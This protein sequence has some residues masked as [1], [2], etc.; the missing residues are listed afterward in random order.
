[1]KMNINS[2]N[3]GI[4]QN[5]HDDYLYDYT[6]N[7]MKYIVKSN[8]K[9]RVKGR[10]HAHDNAIP[11]TVITEFRLKSVILNIVYYTVFGECVE[12]NGRPIRFIYPIH[13]PHSQSWRWRCYCFDI[14]PRTEE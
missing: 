14:E 5:N 9:M 10:V 2:G 4:S 6:V 1:M 8:R 11:L 12:G 7:I 3:F 13:L